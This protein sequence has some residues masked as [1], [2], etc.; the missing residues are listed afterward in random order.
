V[1]GYIDRH[2]ERSTAMTLDLRAD[3]PQTILVACQDSD[4]RPLARERFG[5]RPT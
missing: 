4:I 3:V 2:I 5:D 1:I